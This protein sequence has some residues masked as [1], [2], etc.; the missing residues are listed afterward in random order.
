MAASGAAWVFTRSARRGRSRKSSRA[1]GRSGKPG[2][3]TA[4]L[5]RRRQHRRWSAVRE[6]TTT[7]ARRGGSPA[8]AL[9]GLSRVKSSRA[10]ARLAPPSKP[11]SAPAWRCPPTATPRWRRPPR[12]QLQRGGVGVH[13]LRRRMDP[14][15]REAHGNGETRRRR[16]GYSV[17]LSADGNTALI[18]GPDD[19]GRIG[20]AWVFTRSGSTWTQQGEKL[21]GSGETGAGEFGYSV[22]LV[23]GRQH[24]AD[25]RPSR[26]RRR[27]RRGCSR[28]RVDVDPAG[29]KA[30]RPAS[31]APRLRAVRPQRGTVRRRQHRADRRPC[32][33]QR[34]RNR[35]GVGVHALGVDLDPAGRE[36]HRQRGDRRTAS[37]A[38]AWRCPPT[39]TPR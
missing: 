4:S 1:A 9:L 2:S 5:V 25:R 33:Q 39:A 37:S 35:G 38:S 14:A 24:G 32:L 22:A 7:K 30:Q 26:Q 27:A 36:A 15:G 12:Q 10:A 3:A 23:R 13:A 29:R 19:N 11:S 20:A 28:A 8:Q 34:R 16:F 21:T 6:I 18:G 31:E 17:A